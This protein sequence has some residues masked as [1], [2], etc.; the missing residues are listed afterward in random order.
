MAYALNS[1]ARLIAGSPSARRIQDSGLAPPCARL[2]L[3]TGE[4]AMQT[5]DID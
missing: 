1:P 5:Q 3:T 4:I 2:S